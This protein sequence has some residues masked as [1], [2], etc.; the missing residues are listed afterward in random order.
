[1]LVARLAGPTEAGLYAAVNRLA[2]AG[3]LTWQAAR[4]VV[5]PQQAALLA[6]D[7]RADVQALHLRSTAWITMA[8]WPFY[9]GLIGLAPQVLGLFGPGFADGAA[10]LVVVGLAMLVPTLVGPAQTIALMA[11]WSTAG[12]VVSVVTLMVSVGLT[13]SLAAAYG[14]LGGAIGWSAG[15]VVEAVLYASLVRRRLGFSP[16]GSPPTLV[17]AV[18]LGTVGSALLLAHV[19]H[20]GP[21]GD[22]G[23][24]AAGSAGYLAVLIGLRDKTGLSDLLRFRGARRQD[25]QSDDQ[26]KDT[27]HAAS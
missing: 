20:T 10:A 23:L 25:D 4:L 16:V 8:A 26:S 7:R 22:L 2:L 9:L 21:W 14:A 19:L 6:A 1:V 3:M 17:A 15:V 11:G 13:A 27:A 18:A 24:L 12:L 5:A